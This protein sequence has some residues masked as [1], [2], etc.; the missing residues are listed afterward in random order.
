MGKRTTISAET[1]AKVAL[2]AIR[3]LT[4]VNEIAVKYQI[5]PNMVTKWKK[6]ATEN[7]ASI[8]ADGRTK[9]KEKDD[10]KEKIELLCQEVGHLLCSLSRLKK[11]RYSRLNRSGGSLT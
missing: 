2:E 1:K 4:T 6:Q 8:F 10:S 11:T 9:E 7:L 3:G 5:H